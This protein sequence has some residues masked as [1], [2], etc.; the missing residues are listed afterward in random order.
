MQNLELTFWVIREEIWK[1]LNIKHNRLNESS[2]KGK[3]SKER[4]K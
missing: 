2:F 4:K 1:D 3:W